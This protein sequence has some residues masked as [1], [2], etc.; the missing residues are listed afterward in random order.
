M[1]IKAALSAVAIAAT[2]LAFPPLLP[3]ATASAAVRVR[4]AMSA[5]GDL[6]PYRAIASDTLKIVDIGDL[7]AAKTRVKDLETAWDDAE[8][9]MKPK[10][11]TA[12]SSIDKSIDAA[13]NALRADAPKQ[14][15]C[16]TTLKALIAKMDGV[17]RA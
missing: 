14:A 16:A 10:D 7:A 4:L 5:L 1:P 12:W 15:Q 13:L 2:V 3:S 6:T 17:G 8:A 11:R 9:G